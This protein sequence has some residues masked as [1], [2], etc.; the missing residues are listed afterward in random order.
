MVYRIPDSY[1]PALLHI[2]EEYFSSTFCYRFSF[3][4]VAGSFYFFLSGLEITFDPEKEAAF[5]A[6]WSFLLFLFPVAS[7]YF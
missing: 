4:V 2:A 7:A 6:E 3:C 1:F 5:F